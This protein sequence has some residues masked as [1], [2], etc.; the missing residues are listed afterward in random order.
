M[1]SVISKRAPPPGLFMARISPPCSRAAARQIASPRPTPTILLSERPRWNFSNKRS[2]SPGGRPGPSSATISTSALV[3]G[4]GAYRDRRTGGRVFRGVLQKIAQYLYDQSRLDQNHGQVGWQIQ[5]DAPLREP[6]C[7]SCAARA[8]P[9]HRLRAS[10]PA[11][12]GCQIPSAPVRGH[13]SAAATCRGP[14][15]RS[16]AQRGAPVGIERV[17][18][19]SDQTPRARDR[20]QRCA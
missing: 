19:L 12:C 1:G 17:F 16:N 2:G 3:S 13:S 18:R 14:C 7:A 6:G 10:R 15:V 11:K 20:R 9:S 4:G 5:R 8:R